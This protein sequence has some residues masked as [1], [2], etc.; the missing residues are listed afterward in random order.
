M[1]VRKK[2]VTKKELQLR[3]EKTEDERQ[4]LS[5]LYE[6]KVKEHFAEMQD[7][8]EGLTHVILGLM[9]MGIR[10]DT[11]IAKCNTIKQAIAEQLLKKQKH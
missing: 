8:G 1:A 11:I 10:L 5:A 9:S 3:L 4:K 2:T 7:K 6:D